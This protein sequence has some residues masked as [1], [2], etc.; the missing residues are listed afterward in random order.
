MLIANIVSATNVN[1]SCDFNVVNSLDQT[2]Q[3]LPT[4]IVGWDF[5]KKN[6]PD[7]NIIN[8]KLNENLFW[9]FKKTEKRELHE[10]DIYNFVEKS[11]KNLIKDI[12]Y[13]FIDPILFSRKNIVKIIKA[14]NNTNKVISYKHENMLYIY[15]ER[16]IFGVDLTFTEFI[17]LNNEKLLS[18]INKKSYIFL[19]K[20]TIF[21][22]YKKRIENL[23]NQ[24]KFIPYLYSLENG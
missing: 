9:T 13:T 22:E 1:V 18:K 12:T 24:V 2:V 20:N 10:E 23:E 7:Y 19:D 5:I 3:G 16:Y 11:Y 15:F 14:I 17:G 6:Y 21:I 4:L 8:R